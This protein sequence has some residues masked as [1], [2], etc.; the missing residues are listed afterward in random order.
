MSNSITSQ[1]GHIY[2]DF[3]INVKSLRTLFPG[4]EIKTRVRK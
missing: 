2:A 1:A 3:K 4:E